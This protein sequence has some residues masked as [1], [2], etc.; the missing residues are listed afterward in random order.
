MADDPRKPRFFK[1]FYEKQAMQEN[2][3]QLIYEKGWGGSKWDLWWHRARMAIVMRLLKLTKGSFLEV[4]CAEGLYVNF[5]SKHKQN[6]MV[7][8][9]DWI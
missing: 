2:H 1:D 7:V 3:Q 9:L 4:G 6:V 8:G 5:Y